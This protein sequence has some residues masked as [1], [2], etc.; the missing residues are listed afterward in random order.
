MKYPHSAY[1]RGVLAILQLRPDDKLPGL[2]RWGAVPGGHSSGR[3][4]VIGGDAGHAAR[5]ALTVVGE[6]HIGQG[7]GRHDLHQGGAAEREV[8]ARRF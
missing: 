6:R 8:V 1:P 2:Q 7:R 3:D 5:G 4:S